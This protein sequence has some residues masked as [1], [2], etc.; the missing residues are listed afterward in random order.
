MPAK[1]NHFRW[2][3]HNKGTKA[4]SLLLAVVA[5]WSIHGAIRFE[6]EVGDIPIEILV[7]EG[8][9]ILDRTETAVSVTFRGAKSAVTELDPEQVKVTV[10][11]RNNPDR[12]RDLLWVKLSKKQVEAPPGVRAVKISPDRIGVTLDKESHREVDISATTQGQPPEGYETGDIV[13]LPDKVKLYG[14]RRRL[15]EVEML[16]AAP[17][18]MVGRL[19]SFKVTRDVLP[20]SES[21]VARLEPKTVTV[22]VEVIE[23]SASKEF[24]G[25]SINA[26]RLAGDSRT[27]AL[28]ATNAHV[29][30]EG[31]SER[32]EVLTEQSLL[33][34]VDC[35]S[36]PALPTSPVPVRVHVPAG[37]Q[38]RSIEPADVLVQFE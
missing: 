24:P 12:D 26:M 35:R 2:I 22:Q 10:D 17:I 20:P 23:R 30:V 7:D 4:L 8:W 32:L 9:A 37:V 6:R 31:R 29:V 11:I 34:Y 25:L 15:E 19:A 13:C 3:T 28:S 38:V 1:R 18:E 33:A 14:P 5:F 21:W 16:H 27:V 36:A